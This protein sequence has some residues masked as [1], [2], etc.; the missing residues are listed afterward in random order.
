MEHRMVRGG[1]GRRTWKRR[2]LTPIPERSQRIRMVWGHL[3]GQDRIG[4]V[5]GTSTPASLVPRL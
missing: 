5:Q 3:Q 4:S 1:G 2:E